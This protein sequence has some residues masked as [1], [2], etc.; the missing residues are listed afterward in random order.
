MSKTSIT[1]SMFTSPLVNAGVMKRNPFTSGAEASDDAI[2]VTT[3]A[4]NPGA[5]EGSVQV[6]TCGFCT[7]TAGAGCPPKVTVAPATS[8]FAPWAVTGYPPAA[9]PESGITDITRGAS[10]AEAYTCTGAECA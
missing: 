9:G 5:P 10:A 1:P 2:L 3:T 6:R 7:V 8:K 4:V